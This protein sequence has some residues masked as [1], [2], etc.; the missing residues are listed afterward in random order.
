[1]NSASNTSPSSAPTTPP[2]WDQRHFCAGTI[3]ARGQIAPITMIPLAEQSGFI[4]E[5]GRWVL[6]QACIDRLGG[7]SSGDGTVVSV[8]VSAY[9]LMAP[10]FVAMVSTILSDTRS[11]PTPGHLE[12]TEGALLRDTQR[13]HIVLNQ[14]KQLG[15]LLALDDF[16][17][18]YS[19]LE[20]PQ[21]IPR[22]RREDRSDLHHRYRP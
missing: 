13:A 5:I 1:M 10:D 11:D 16:G 21:A 14:L 15:L 19:S 2:W 8:N 18:G 6:E 4:I 3:P 12:I 9:Q 20:L 7:E 22:R 17:T